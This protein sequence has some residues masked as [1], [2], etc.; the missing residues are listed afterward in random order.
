MMH[1]DTGSGLASPE[2]MRR[3]GFV[4]LA[5]S[6]CIAAYG[7]DA[8]PTPVDWSVSA[9]AST[10]A[11]PDSDN[12]VEVVVT[13][14]ERWLHLEGRCNYESLETGSAWMGYNFSAGKKLSFRVTPMAGAVFGKTAGLGAGDRITVGWRRL[15]L[16]SE[17]EWV[18]N[19]RARGDSFLY[20]WSELTVSPSHW[21][22]LGLVGQ[23]TRTY[24][25]AR[26]IQRG[27]LLGLRY[28]RVEI[29]ANVLNPDQQ[30]PVYI[31]SASAEF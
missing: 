22:R 30:K 18:F 26:D 8:A 2:C 23:R 11:V 24:K 17:A 21:L 20:M 4:V 29:T 16:N 27:L 1:D 6:C 31:I 10:Y 25:T 15:T 13:A 14:D 7:Q 19:T 3:G 28:K 9:A 5:F 12:Y